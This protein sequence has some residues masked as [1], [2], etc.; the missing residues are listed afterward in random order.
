MNDSKK[1]RGRASRKRTVAKIV[2]VFQ[3]SGQISLQPKDIR[4]YAKLTQS[5]F[6]NAMSE[7]ILLGSFD[8]DIT[9]DKPPK[10]FYVHIDGL[11]ENYVKQYE[12]KYEAIFQTMNGNLGPVD[13]VEHEIYRNGISFLKQKYEKPSGRSGASIPELLILY[14]RWLRLASRHLS[15]I[16]KENYE[17]SILKE[18]INCS[19]C[20]FSSHIGDA[21]L[22]CNRNWMEGGTRRSRLKAKDDSCDYWEV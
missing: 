16:L 5:V 19:F 8:R 17:E 20:R 15:R 12:T 2:K 9:Y 14:Y 22:Q 10:T 7:L 18:W 3:E 13:L 1:I 11:D 21:F 4:T 6:N